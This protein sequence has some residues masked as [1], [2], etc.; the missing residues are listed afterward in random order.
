MIALETC[1]LFIDKHCLLCHTET[2]N[3]YPSKENT[4]TKT[5]LALATLFVLVAVMVISLGTTEEPSRIS[6]P[7]TTLPVAVQSTTPRHVYP[8]TP[9]ADLP[10]PDQIA[11][12]NSQ[13]MPAWNHIRAYYPLPKLRKDFDRFMART[14]DGDVQIITMSKRQMA[15]A[16]PAMATRVNGRLSVVL[17]IPAWMDIWNEIGERE[18]IADIVVAIMLHEQYHLD[19]HYNTPPARISYRQRVENES[20]AW[21]YSLEEC[22]LPMFNEGRLSNLP[23]DDPDQAITNAVLAYS[24]A[25]GDRRHPAWQEFVESVSPPPP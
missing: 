11:F 8:S 17:C 2:S 3:K 20:E 10:S 22:Y 19:H 25:K 4:V 14:Q 6:P 12:V 23:K 5:S 21:W 13:L 18:T 24:I 7:K 15:G 9:D 1:P 16:P